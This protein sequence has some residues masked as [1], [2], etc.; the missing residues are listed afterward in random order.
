ME[1]KKMVDPI[2]IFEYGKRTHRDYEAQANDSAMQ[3]A[4]GTQARPGILRR[5]LSMS[6]VN[7]FST[8]M[9]WRSMKRRRH[10]IPCSDACPS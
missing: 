3:R 2:T 6:W 10:S 5:I 7:V 9:Q 1:V 4:A 8:V